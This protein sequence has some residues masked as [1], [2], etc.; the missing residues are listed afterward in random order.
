MCYI[1]IEKPHNTSSYLL[2]AGEVIDNMPLFILVIVRFSQT[3]TYIALSNF[4]I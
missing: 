2:T 4:T 1:Q 3:F